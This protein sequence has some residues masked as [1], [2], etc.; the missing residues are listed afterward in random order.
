MDNDSHTDTNTPDHGAEQS[1]AT[2]SSTED[3]AKD[4]A[5]GLKLF[6]VMLS[7]CM[8]TSLVGLELGIISTAIPGITDDFHRIQDVGWYGCAT[9]LL[10]ASSSSS[11]GKVYKYLNVKIAY[12]T[13]IVLLMIG[14]VVSAA[15]P[16]S[17]AVIV[18]RAIQGLGV[19]GTL[20]GSVII[21]NL[22][23]HPK[24]HPML[25]GIWT[26]LLIITT[27]L[28]P[29]IGGAF[30]A[31]VTWRWCFWINLPAGGPSIALLDF[32]GF[33]FL[34][35]SLAG[36]TEAWN[37]GSTIALLV[38]WP[39]FSII[40]IVIEWA[41]GPR[42][43]VP[44]KIFRHRLTWANALFAFFT[45]AANYQV[46]FYLPIYFQSIHGQSAISSG[47]N[48]LPFLA[49]FALGAVSSGAV[50][51][52][53]RYLQPYQLIS[54]LLTT[55]G[56][57]LFYTLEADSSK[58]RYIGPQILFG[59]GLGFGNQIPMTAVQ[60]LSKP[61]DMASSSGIVL[62]MQALSGTYFILIAGSIFANRMLHRLETTYPSIDA[63]KVIATGASE[64][65]KVFHGA[66]L[67]AVVDA[68]MDGIKDVF[69][70]SLAASAVT[71]LVALVVP[72]K[73]LP[74]HSEK[75]TTDAG[76]TEKAATV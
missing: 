43:I 39:V 65:Q 14:S 27:I 55:A 8:S 50:I 70:F 68:Y 71:V 58:A 37:A 75:K 23:S 41:Q 16:N 29:L 38:L 76:D 7:I 56:M 46:I 12:L 34:L 5:T 53:T 18:G 17:A 51:G 13:A 20:S 3:T 73:R 67:A 4:Y 66:D 22:V 30:T 69:A 15:A 40:F 11:W 45:N 10:V 6:L 48:M 25:I 9:F 1:D 2:L 19:A 62:M 72:F 59:F 54:G 61:E 57:A 24:L 52:K 49:F 47:V 44:L 21:I 35:A 36:Q 33:T 31:E 26:A 28:G 60:G 64:L 74:D 42:A 63:A 32:P